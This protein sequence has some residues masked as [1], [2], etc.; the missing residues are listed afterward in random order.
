MDRNFFEESSRR[1]ESLDETIKK[2]LWNEEA[3]KKRNKILGELLF[4][5][6]GKR[7]RP[8]KDTYS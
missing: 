5:K 4:P 1:V 3:E 8:R 6:P 7:Y 2:S